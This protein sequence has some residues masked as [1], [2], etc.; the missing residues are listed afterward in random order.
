MDEALLRAPTVLIFDDL[1]ALCG[2]AVGPEGEAGHDGQYFKRNS[3]VF[4]E[5][6]RRARTLKVRFVC[7]NDGTEVMLFDI[8]CALIIQVCFIVT[9]NSWSSL[10]ESLTKTEGLHLFADTIEMRPPSRTER[11]EIFKVLCRERDLHL[12]EVPNFTRHTEG[13]V[14]RDLATLAD[15]VLLSSAKFR[16]KLNALMKKKLDSGG[17]NE[18]F[19]H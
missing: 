16:R 2:Q 18:S 19:I 17:K 10:C 6:V 8:C 7:E 1:D 13:F 4:M 11:T 15:R 12:A 3:R 9:A 14:A 5:L